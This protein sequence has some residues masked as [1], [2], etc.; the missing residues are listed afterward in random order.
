MKHLLVQPGQEFSTL[1]KEFGDWTG[2]LCSYAIDVDGITVD[3]NGRSSDLSSS[4][5]LELLKSLRS[6]ADC[7]VTT[8]E[9]ARKES[10]KSST[11][12]PI[13]FITRDADSLKET[14]AFSRSG[15]FQNIVFSDFDDSELFLKV[16]ASLDKQGFKKLL[17]EGGTSSLRALIS[18]VKTVSI[19]AS[20]S[21]IDS[22]SSIDQARA[23][24]GLVGDGLESVVT[25]D[26]ATDTNRII[27]WAVSVS[28]STQ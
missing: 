4:F 2:W 26:I 17:F 3:K 19:V 8:G 12:A 9:T 18:Q 6:S 1:K 7:I 23:L 13:A 14:P 27:Q 25:K 20:L 15:E 5:D 22:P 21:N 28:S 24:R 10:Y 16:Q 11:Y